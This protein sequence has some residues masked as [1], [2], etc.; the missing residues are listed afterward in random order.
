M[1]G[2][3]FVP[4]INPKPW[5]WKI[6]EWSLYYRDDINNMFRI[7]LDRIYKMDK[8]SLNNIDK[9]DLY[10]KFTKFLFKRSTKYQTSFVKYD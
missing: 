10:N 5:E 1:E 4:R 6:K 2:K 9:Q 8:K 3:I 7:L